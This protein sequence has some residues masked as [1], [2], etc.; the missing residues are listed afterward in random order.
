M[1]RAEL[2]PWAIAVFSLLVLLSL[3]RSSR[4]MLQLYRISAA[5]ASAAAVFVGIADHQ[6]SW[7][8]VGAVSLVAKAGIL[9]TLGMRLLPK[10]YGALS[11]G[12]PRQAFGASL[13][14]L[15]LVAAYGD[16]GWLLADTLVPLLL[17]ALRRDAKG[18]ALLFLSAE[19]GVFLLETALDPHLTLIAAPFFALGDLILIAIVLFAAL[20]GGTFPSLDHALDRLPTTTHQDLEGAR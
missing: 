20:A 16:L 1:V 3:A 11:S 8:V 18:R 19:L 5:V 7:V 10:T 2:L 4:Q 17:A 15:C 6:V 14:A 9:P 12:T 13:L